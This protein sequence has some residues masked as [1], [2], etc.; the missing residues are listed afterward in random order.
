MDT[1]AEI[2]YKQQTCTIRNAKW[3]LLLNEEEKII[4][5]QN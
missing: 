4:W 1:E 2:I 3:S 5:D